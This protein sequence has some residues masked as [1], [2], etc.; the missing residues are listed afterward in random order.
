MMRAALAIAL[1]AG[2]H[3]PFPSPDPLPDGAVIAP[4]PP[5]AIVADRVSDRIELYRLAP[6]LERAAEWSVYTNPDYVPNEPF[7]LAVSP[8]RDSIYV[9]MGHSVGPG[10]G[11]LL[12]LRLSD[13]ARLG[14]VMV[15]EQ[16]SMLALSSDGSR[17]YVGL[18]R[19]LAHPSGP[20]T[21]R[22][23]LAVVDTTSMRLIATVEVC[24]APMGVVLDE[25][26]ARA[27]VACLGDDELALVDLSGA[28]K[29][30]RFV[31]LTDGNVPA[32]QPAYLILDRTH[33]FVTAQGSGELWVLDR[34]S[35][36]V[37]KRL[38]FG[39]DSFPQRLALSA[40]GQLVFVNVDYA[41]RIAAI[42]TSALEELASVPLPGVNPQGIALSHDGSF[43]LVTDESD[44]KTP[45]RLV[46]VT[47]ENLLAGG[48]HFSGSAPSEIF[49]QALLLIE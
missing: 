2:C 12:K 31:L 4:S 11:T 23:G 32:S 29:L 19:N 28:P 10:E 14:E 39:S 40:D 7:D 36:Q 25:A 13:G 45:G 42:S 35:A 41:N 24:A 34:M 27:W 44:L 33:A 43:A 6:S 20:W 46:R 38:P 16:P 22:G 47:L 21:D 26:N 18:F 1:F 5:L 3:A 48:A 9:V 30:D 15:G 37:V 49:P 17:A 8:S